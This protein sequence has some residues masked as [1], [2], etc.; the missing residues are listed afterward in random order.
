M[1]ISNIE[2]NSQRELREGL[3]EVLHKTLYPEKQNH[4]F[5]GQET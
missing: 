3:Q 1:T 5:C 4:V 2:D